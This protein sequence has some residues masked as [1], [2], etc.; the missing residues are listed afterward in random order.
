[1]LANAHRTHDVSHSEPMT[2]RVDDEDDEDDNDKPK[3]W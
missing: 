3:L 2:L 1:M